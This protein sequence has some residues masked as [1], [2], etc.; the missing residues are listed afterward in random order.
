MPSKAAAAQ[1]RLPP[2]SNIRKPPQRRAKS[3]RLKGASTA[4]EVERSSTESTQ[5]RLMFELSSICAGGKGL[6]LI[7]LPRFNICA[8]RIL[9]QERESP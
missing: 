5:G 3:T 4:D 6:A 9:R 8:A 1:A 7:G 2:H